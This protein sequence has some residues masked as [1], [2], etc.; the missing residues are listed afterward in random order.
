MLPILA[1]VI[2]GTAGFLTAFFPRVIP[3]LTNSYYSLIRAKTRVV[4][5]DYEK[6]PVRV[7]GGGILLVEIVWLFIRFRTGKGF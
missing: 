4:V 2:I 3:D 6:L 1:L 7:A 5:E